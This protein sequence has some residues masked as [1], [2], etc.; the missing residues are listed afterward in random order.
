MPCAVEGVGPVIQEAAYY[1]N[2]TLG[3]YRLLR[4][5]YRGGI[6]RLREQMAHREERFLQLAESR[7][8]ANPR[9][10]Y[11]ELFRLA[12]CELSDLADSVKRCGL[13]TTLSRLA[14][15][16]VYLSHDEFKGKTPLVRGGREIRFTPDVLLNP[17]GRGY[18][19]SLSS[20]SRSRGTPTRKGL[21]YRLYREGYDDLRTREFALGKRAW[22]QIYPTLPSSIGL[23]SSIRQAR[24][25]QKTERWFSV[26]GNL[27]DSGHYRAVT[28]FLVTFG[29]CMGAHLP[30]PRYLPPNDFLP[31]AKWVAER[32]REGRPCAIRSYVSSAVRVV[33][34]ARE[35]NL[36]ISGTVFFAG[37]EALTVPKRAVIENAGCEIYPSYA[38]SE[39]GSVG[40]AC[41]QMKTGNCVHVFRDSLAV[42]SCMRL[43]PLAGL[44]LSSLMFTNLLPFA[45]RFLINAEMGDG[46]VIEPAICH[47]EY[48]AAG[49]TTQ[50]RGIFSYGKLTGQGITLVGSDVLSILETSLPRRFGG[51]PGDY[52]LVEREGDGQTEIVLRI[53]PRVQ[54]ASPADVR[55]FFLAEL[56][57]RYGGTLAARL[58][59]H[60][61]GFT[62]VREEPCATGGGKVLPLHVLGLEGRHALCDVG[63]C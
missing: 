31:A 63:R 45:P 34:A 26:S 49:M 29:R 47:C 27:R 59:N 21:E 9:N 53:S 6:D 33:A 5:P 46:G 18:I 56:Q 51:A 54:L 44:E 28:N 48:S 7:V 19:E 55:E 10:P 41:R 30:Y 62:V 17:S 23:A 15:E 50:I 13:E 43:A 4:T 61:A 1:A 11:H 2:M 12:G 35:A 38:I 16:G 42:I 22:G 37:G 14:A 24:A 25:G 40:V 58:W 36:D 32:K 20:G 3:V 60:S 57:K 8:L 39:I 52:Q